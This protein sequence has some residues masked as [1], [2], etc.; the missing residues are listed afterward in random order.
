MSQE[1]NETCN[2]P[3]KGITEEL[4]ESYINAI[5]SGESV[6]AKLRPNYSSYDELYYD[7][8]R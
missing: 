5:N 2:C 4:F 7:E 3:L 1:I 6:V 8:E